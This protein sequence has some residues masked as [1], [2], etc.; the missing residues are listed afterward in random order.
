MACQCRPMRIPPSNCPARSQPPVFDYR[1]PHTTLPRV[2]CLGDSISGPSCRAAARHPLLAG[3]FELRSVEFIRRAAEENPVL[4]N[5]MTTTNL[6]KCIASWVGGSCKGSRSLPCPKLNASASLRW[7]AVVLNAGAWDLSTGVNGCC[8]VSSSR[9]H[10]SV[11][12]VRTALLKV[13]NYAEVALWVTTTPVAENRGCCQSANVLNATLVAGFGNVAQSLGYCAHDARRLNSL[14]ATMI[15]STF[16]ANRVAIAD[17]HSAV[18]THCGTAI[19]DFRYDDCD[20]QSQNLGC[21]VHFLRSSFDVVHGPPIALALAS[22]LGVEMSLSPPLLVPTVPRRLA[23]DVASRWSGDHMTTSDVSVRSLLSEALRIKATSTDADLAPV[24]HAI[25]DRVDMLLKQAVSRGNNLSM[26][27]QRSDQ[28]YLLEHPFTKQASRPINA[29]AQCDRLR[30]QRR[31]LEAS[32]ERLGVRASAGRV[33]ASGNVSALRAALGRC[34]HAKEQLNIVTLGCSMTEGQM[35]CFG[36]DPAGACFGGC[37]RF[38]WCTRLQAF[39]SDILPCRVSVVCGKRGQGGAT[40]AHRFSSMVARFQPALVISHLAHC[41]TYAP[42]HS[43]KIKH[44]LAGAESVVRRAAALPATLLHVQPIGF[45]PPHGESLCTEPRGPRA[46]HLSLWRHYQLPILNVAHAVC[47]FDSLLGPL[48]Q[49]TGGCSPTAA[50]CALD[51]DEVGSKC[52]L[53]PGPHTHHIYAALIT[54]WVVEQAAGQACALSGGGRMARDPTST[55][56][57]IPTVTVEPMASPDALAG[58]E[59]CKTEKRPTSLDFSSDCGKPLSGTGPGRGSWR[60]FADVPGRQGWIAFASPA[61]VRLSF[62]V[63]LHGSNS[64]ILISYLRSYEGF[65]SAKMW[66]DDDDALSVSLNGHWASPTSEPWQ[67][68]IAAPALCGPSCSVLSKHRGK[69]NNHRH[70]VNVRLE[71]EVSQSTRKFKVMMLETCY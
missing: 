39:L 56:P 31:E 18:A 49:W 16:P 25:S 68:V 52:W 15:R 32:L 14:I 71:P 29:R 65:G 27:N 55:W 60:C 30:D 12:N 23:A 64:S 26:R 3:R 17:T 46:A 36:R 58:F 7:K 62:S 70:V 22:L 54:E 5:T 43:P 50:S 20:I 40:Y 69:K 53:H 63:L 1:V 48:R 28:R 21:Q 24:R 67:R 51:I 6:N 9:L 66:L 42:E 34:L 11:S 61:V 44:L 37:V 19:N 57:L 2:L 45:P 41:D 8:A 38:R 13:L 35:S 59:L 4:L 47:A 33:P 10:G